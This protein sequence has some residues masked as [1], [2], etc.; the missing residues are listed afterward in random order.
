MKIYSIIVSFLIVNIFNATAADYHIGPNQDFVSI[1]TVPWKSLTVGDNVFIHWRSEDDGGAYK[2]KWVVNIAGTAAKPFTISGVLGPN[3]ERPVIDG[4]GAVTRPELNYWSE[5][6]GVI[7]IGGS[8]IPSNEVASYIIIENLEIKSAHPD[9]SFTNDEGN[10]ETYQK[11]ATSI[12]IESG[13]HVTVRNCVLT[14]SGN[15]LFSAHAS[16]NLLI[17]KNNI[18]ANGIVGSPFGHING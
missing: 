10:V 6:R 7:K 16:T 18:Y 12:F 5:V 14:N 15:G 8:S 11:N 9:Y 17:E 3:G 2:E 13:N 4:N 1:N